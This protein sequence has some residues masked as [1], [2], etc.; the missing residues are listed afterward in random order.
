MK[1]AIIKTPFIVTQWFGRDYPYYEEEEEQNTFQVGDEV[2]VLH[3]ATPNPM[4]RLFVV[5]SPKINQATV[6]TESYLE[7]IS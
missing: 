1:K 3:E 2:V 4:G 6:V 5:F 7:F